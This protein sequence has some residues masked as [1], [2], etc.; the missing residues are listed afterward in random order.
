M[1]KQKVAIIGTGSLG[2]TIAR[3]IP[4]HVGEYYELVGLMKHSEKGIEALENEFQ[5]PVVRDLDDLLKLKPDFIVEAASVDVVKEIGE[6][7]LSEGIHFIP[8]SVGGLVEEAF[9]TNLRQ[10]AKENNCVL[11]IPS[12]AIGG[13]D[14]MRKMALA[15]SPR[16]T[17]QSTKPLQALMKSPYMENREVSETEKE[18][19]F[20]GTAAEAIKA[21]P[22]SINVAVA[23]AL[24]TVGPEN[25]RT[26]M[27]SDP[28]SSVNVHEIHLEN[29]ES[30]VYLRFG[31]KPSDNPTSSAITAWSVIS[32][33]QNIAEPIRFF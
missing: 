31:G 7:I 16:V 20:D 17:F 11:Y 23:T 3:E 30:S 19:V 2:K 29:S 5:T 8:L 9:Y 12:G 22:T 18:T 6:K 13:F 15:D 10:T 28:E 26:M 33:L 25:T 4:N 32:L 21:F 24:A 27:T 14:I 1:T